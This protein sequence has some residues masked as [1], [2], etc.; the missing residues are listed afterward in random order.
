MTIMGCRGGP[1]TRDPGLYTCQNMNLTSLMTHAYNIASYQ[2]S[3][4]SWIDDARFDIR[5]KVHEGA[6]S[7]DF[8][9]MLQNLLAERFKLAVHYE[10]REIAKYDLVVAK[11][12]PKLKPPIE[13]ASPNGQPPAP[14]P[15]GRDK[16]GYPV[17]PPGRQGMA[18]MNGKAR[19]YDP[20]M[21]MEM[22]ATR[23]GGQM[24]KPV[25]DATGLT[26]KYEIALSWAFEM[27]RSAAP[28]GPAAVGG[29]NTPMPTASI[30]DGDSGPTLEKAI[31]D[32]L[33]L[34]L[35]AKKGAVDF[36][37]VDHVEKTPSEN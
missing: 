15:P 20:G 24:R 11:N 36:L 6:T 10:S 3:A 1:E 9:L 5:A 37:V 30:P 26:G 34:R 14:G 22:L 16:E 29:G 18:M 12:G 2:L 27:M 28:L 21:T 31:Q 4:P 19:L 25:T 32:Q 17:L 8:R 35:E 33:G 13:P 7:D 23:L